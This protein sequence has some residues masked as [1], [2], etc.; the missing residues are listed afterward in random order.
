MFAPWLGMVVFLGIWELTVRLGDLKPFQL[1][2]P[3]VVIRRL[4]EEPGFWWRNSVVTGREAMIGFAL[5]FL[6]ALVIGAPLA[7]SRF[8][9]RATQPILV[10]IQVTP[11][12]AY[13]PSVVIW[14]GFGWR[15]I[16]FLTALACFPLFAF[17]VI[18]GIRST[19]PA[20]LEL[21][22]SVDASP[23]ETWRRLRLPSALPSLFPAARASI[24]LALI[25]AFL[26]EQFALTPDGL[27][28]IGK[29]GAAFND[30]DLVWG[31]V[32]CMAILGTVA[33]AS[34][35]LAERWVL[36]W[37]ASQRG[38]VGYRPRS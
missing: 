33:L 6:S 26:A 15:P 7:A 36:R 30:G 37:H 31:T 9:E 3:S 4:S 38:V 10:L 32:F 24:G 28:V 1:R 19:D 34:V 8:A 2:A 23:A 20:A 5:A 13:A 22:R 12:V 14:F 29:K 11:F 25:V 27:G 17:A 18:G 35:G 16:I 21:F